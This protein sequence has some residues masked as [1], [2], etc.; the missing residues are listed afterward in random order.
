LENIKAASSG[1]FYWSHQLTNNTKNAQLRLIFAGQCYLLAKRAVSGVR[2]GAQSVA[3][4]LL[5]YK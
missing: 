5:L 3:N 1:L 2:I 4:L